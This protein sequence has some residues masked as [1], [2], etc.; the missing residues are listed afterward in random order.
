V[1]DFQFVPLGGSGGGS[2][3]ISAP[4]SGKCLDV[5]GGASANGTKLQE[6]TCNGTSAQTFHLAPAP[7]AA[8]AF[9]V[10]HDASGKCVDIAGSGT[11]DFTRAQLWECNATGAQSFAVQDVGG[12][13]VRFVNTNSGKCLDINGASPADG[14]Q[15]QLYTC[16]NTVAQTWHATP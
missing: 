7:N 13:N 5:A 9:I 2:G 6:W 4:F 1:R 16:N 10:V 3:T 14:T 11:A 12:G 8:G 15:V